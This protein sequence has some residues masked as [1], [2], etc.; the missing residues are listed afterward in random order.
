VPRLWIFSPLYFDVESYLRL[1]GELR[2]AVRASFELRPVV[3]D[4]SA[5]LDAQIAQLPADVRVVVPPFNLGHQRALVHGLRKLSSE[6]ADDDFV[7]T[8][9]GD[10]ED[11]PRDLPRLLVTLTA[12]PA[13]QRRIA[14]AARTRRREAPF[15]KL[16]Y[17]IFKR[18]FLLLTG[19][20]VRSGNYAAYRG[21]VAKNVLFHPHFDLCY[22]SSLLS[23]NLQIERVPCERGARYAGVSKM[24]YGKLLQHGFRMLMPFADRIAVRGLVFSAVLVPLCLLGALLTA[25]S[26]APGWPWIFGALSLL[27]AGALG[28]CLLLFAVH[29]QSQG[30][31]MARL[32]E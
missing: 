20:I 29:S 32:R 15:F 26:G 22:A 21:W 7:V 11:Q 31:S 23:L 25:L 19:T 16:L 18:F 5:G 17:A 4:D 14:L 8:I 2:A 9:D 24:T 6:I 10:G 27:G 13:N 12:D 1:L 28:T 3:I 30:L